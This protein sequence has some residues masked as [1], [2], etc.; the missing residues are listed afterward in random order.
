L[1][2]EPTFWP[3][4]NT[5]LRL[6]S[7][8]VTKSRFIYTGIHVSDLERAIRFYSRELGM[9]PLFESSTI[10]ETGG[11]VAWMRSAGSKQILETNQYPKGYRYGG[12]SGL[13]HLAFQ[14]GRRQG[15]YAHGQGAQGNPLTV[16]ERTMEVGVRRT[17]TATGLN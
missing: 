3:T 14:V 15:L 5:S 9:K 16:R 17:L 12:K 13:D 7:L 2:A 6:L 11:K 1:D 10:R 4:P 8:I